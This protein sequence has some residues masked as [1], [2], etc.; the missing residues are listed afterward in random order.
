MGTLQRITSNY[1]K[2]KR[3]K[4]SH[5]NYES[6]NTLVNIGVTQSQSIR[7]GTSIED[8]LRIYISSTSSW[9][10]VKPPNAKGKKE[11]DHLFS[12]TLENGKT[13]KIYAELKS[14]LQLDS[15]KRSKTAEKVKSIVHEENC[16]GYITALRHFSPD[17]LSKSRHVNFYTERDVDVLSVEEYFNVLNIA[18]PFENEEGYKE[19]IRFI[20]D[21]LIEE[22]M[23]D[24]ERIAITTLTELKTLKD[25]NHMLDN[26][27]DC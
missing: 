15:E 9:N 13:E 2:D 26:E 23:L 11:R 6:I 19:W 4:K 3:P 1:F 10:D 25:A 8:L 22:D 14:N 27:T 17:T 21:R 18:C 12:R 5:D 24:E 7:I 20:V 16:D